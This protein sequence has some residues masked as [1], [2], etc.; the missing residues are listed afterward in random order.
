LRPIGSLQ[1]SGKNYNFTYD[2][3]GELTY[4]LVTVNAFKES[5]ASIAAHSSSFS[6]AS[7]AEA[8]LLKMICAFVALY[9]SKPSRMH[10]LHSLQS[11]NPTHV[12]GHMRRRHRYLNS[13]LRIICNMVSAV[14]HLGLLAGSIGKP[15]FYY[16]HFRLTSSDYLIGHMGHTGLLY[17]HPA[18]EMDVQVWIR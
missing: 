3:Y 18:S 13:C 9:S 15:K 6:S 16:R 5:R 4:L 12:Q 7:S 17:F 11:A 1:Q 10:M 8:L 14:P 2:R